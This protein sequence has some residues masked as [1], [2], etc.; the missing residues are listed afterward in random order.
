[1]YLEGAFNVNDR[2]LN[3]RFQ[4]EGEQEGVL[5]FLYLPSQLYHT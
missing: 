2:E 4:V 5:S 1:M 3:V